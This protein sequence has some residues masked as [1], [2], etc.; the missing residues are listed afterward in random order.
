[1]K[2]QGKE[3]LKSAFNNNHN[4]VSV[5]IRKICGE[6]IGT[7]A[8]RDVYIFKGDDDYVV[9]VERDMSNGNFANIC[10]WRNYINNKDWNFLGK[11]LAECTHIN[12]TGEILIQERVYHKDKTL[13]P[14]K[15]P[16]YFTDLKTTNFGWTKKGKFVSCDYSFFVMLTNSKGG[17]LK[18]AK[19]W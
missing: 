7:G 1:M 16:K 15:I 18:N 17:L 3:L 2:K 19:W 10:E 8:Y 11:Y 5:L 4:N 6:L 9:K 12:Q 14:K 13:Y